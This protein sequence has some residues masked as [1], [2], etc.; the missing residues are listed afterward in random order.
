[1]VKTLLI[2]AW[3]SFFILYGLGY[4]ARQKV[5]QQNLPDWTWIIFWAKYDQNLSHFRT[6]LIF[7]ATWL[8]TI[9]QSKEYTNRTFLIEHKLDFVRNM[10]EIWLIFAWS[11]FFRLHGSWLLRNAKGLPTYLAWLNINHISSG[12][13]SKSDSYSHEAHFHAIWAWLLSM[14]KSIPTELAWLNMNYILSKI[15]SESESFSHEAH[16]SC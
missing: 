11:S 13:W 9:E 2:F 7:H 3:S 16:F 10:V 15:W 6:K 12:I 4:E 1:M 8:V 5:Y 14:A